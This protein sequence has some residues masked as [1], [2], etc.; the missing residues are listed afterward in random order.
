MTKSKKVWLLIDDRK[1]NE[2]QILGVAEALKWPFEIKKVFYTKWIKLHNSLKLNKLWGIQNKHDFSSNYPDIL[3]G[4]GRRSYMLALW[5]KNKSPKT[6]VIWLMNPGVIGR[7]YADLVVIP[8]H[9]GDVRGKNILRVIG[10]P[11]RITDQKLKIEK[12]KWKGVFEKYPRPRLSMIVGGKTKAFD[13]TKEMA[14][15]LC[16][17]V[18]KLKPSSVLITT[19]RRTPLEVIDVIKKTFNAKS[20]FLY[21]FGDKGDNPYMGLLSWADKIVVT[22]DSMSMCSECCATGVPVMIF[23]PKGNMSSKHQRL[24]Q[25]LYEKGFATPLGSAQMI[26]GGKLNC[27]SE[28][29]QKIKDLF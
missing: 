14:E 16:Q 1:G 24:H 21:Q 12:E 25:M 11:H 13:F 18:L 5:I 20:T 26:F 2:N 15:D 10:S 9:D 27:S 23:A 4:A 29:A 6:K 8:E 7:K 19:S 28:I 22:G 3:I 17:N